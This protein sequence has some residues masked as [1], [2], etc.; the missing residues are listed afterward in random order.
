MPIPPAAPAV[1]LLAGLNLLKATRNDTSSIIE[2]VE[3]AVSTFLM[4]QGHVPIAPNVTIL[5]NGEIVT[6]C[7]AIGRFAEPM[8][9]P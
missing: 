4:E 8:V 9:A 7:L 2:A 3:S 1:F 6:D 5:A